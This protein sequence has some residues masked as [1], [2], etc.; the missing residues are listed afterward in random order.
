M[1]RISEDLNDFSYI[2]TDGK[3]IFIALECRF[4][5]MFDLHYLQYISYRKQRDFIITNYFYQFLLKNSKVDKKIIN[6]CC[7]TDLVDLSNGISFDNVLQFNQNDLALNLERKISILKTFDAVLNDFK[8]IFI[9]SDRIKSINTKMKKVISL[10]D[11][12]FVSRIT[13]NESI[14][15]K[16]IS[17]IGVIKKY[18]EILISE[19]LYNSLKK[20]IDLICQ[21]IED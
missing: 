7:F 2:K 16:I 5:K 18:D 12:S 17:K 11:E 3:D 13:D 21:S 6:S 20:E 1:L 9:V 15:N 19:L 14:K 4:V 10:S 8:K